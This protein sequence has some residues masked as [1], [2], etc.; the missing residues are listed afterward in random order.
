MSSSATSTSGQSGAL[1]NYIGGRFHSNQFEAGFYLWAIMECRLCFSAQESRNT[2]NPAG[3]VLRNII[4]HSLNTLLTVIGIGYTLPPSL[5]QSH[6]IYLA[7]VFLSI[8][9]LCEAVIKNTEQCFVPLGAAW[10]GE[11]GG[12]QSNDSKKCGLIYLFLVD[13]LCLP[14]HSNYVYNIIQSNIPPV[15]LS[16]RQKHALSQVT[17]AA[18]LV[19]MHIQY[20]LY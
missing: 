15:S 4:V 1:H 10:G 3:T 2:R 20:K 17:K 19:H 7:F 16:P 14:V 8:S 12:S 18:L 13:D 6:V 11:E 5:K 9:S